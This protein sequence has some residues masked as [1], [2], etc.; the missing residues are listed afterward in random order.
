MILK[1]EESGHEARNVG[2]LEARKNKQ[3]SSRA[4]ERTTALPTV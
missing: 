3:I 4:P 1:M 2:D